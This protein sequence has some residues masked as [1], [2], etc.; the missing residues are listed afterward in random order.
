MRVRIIELQETMS[1]EKKKFKTNLKCGNC[2][3]KVKTQLDA[4]DQIISWSVDL[5]DPNRIL[6]VETNDP[7][8]A[9][10]VGEILTGAGYRSE[11]CSG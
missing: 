4:A 5:K 6:T 2:V 3:A 1:M 10:V 9:A 11:A 7:D 8:I